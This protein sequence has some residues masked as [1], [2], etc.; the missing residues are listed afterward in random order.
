LV[1]DQPNLIE[2][3]RKASGKP[4]WFSLGL[5]GLVLI[6]LLGLLLDAG[7]PHSDEPEKAMMEELWVGV[8]LSGRSPMIW[9]PMKR[10]P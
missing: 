1:T 5:L 6:L 10:D 9:I 7:F 2:V 4:L 3:V 8:T